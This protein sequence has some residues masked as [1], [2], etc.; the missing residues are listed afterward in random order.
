MKDAILVRKGVGIKARNA[1]GALFNNQQFA[2]LPT[3]QRLSQARGWQSMDVNVRGKS[4]KFVNTHLEA[5]DEGTIREDQATE[6]INGPL[7][8]NPAILVGDLNSDERSADPQSP[9]AM[10]RLLAAGFRDLVRQFST[11]SHTTGSRAFLSAQEPQALLNNANDLAVESR[12]DHILTN[13]PFPMGN[14]GPLDRS[15]RQSSPIPP[16]KTGNL[17]LSDH[18]GVFAT[19][20]SNKRKKK[21]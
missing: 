9:P 6:L 5:G 18:V 14:S 12:I 15:A 16:D 1:T 20:G 3:G 11:S 10:Q 21:K 2:T 17:W 7:S 13:G 8:Q 4:F 19:L